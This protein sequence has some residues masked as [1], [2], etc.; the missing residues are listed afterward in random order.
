MGRFNIAPSID[1]K[2][3][4]P[5]DY[6]PPRKGQKIQVPK[7][8]VDPTFNPFEQGQKSQGRTI[9]PSGETPAGDWEK[10][11]EGLE[12][13]KPDDSG[14]QALII[15]SDDSPSPVSQTV[16]NAYLQI[17]K[18]FILTNVKSGVM[19][20]HQYRADYRI[21]Y[22]RIVASAGNSKPNAQALLFSKTVQ[23]TA[24]EDHIFASLKDEL[25]SLGFVF[26]DFGPGAYL[27]SALPVDFPESQLEDFLHGII[28]SFS[29]QEKGIEVNFRDEIAK[30]IA[31]KTA[32][33]AG[34]ILKNEEMEN[35]INTLFSTSM[36]EIDPDG[37]PVV[38][39]LLSE[40]LDRFF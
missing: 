40:E 36:P 18:K 1:F 23:L 4:T 26:E 12:D 5:F 13:I 17:E 9:V 38:R 28:D 8:T 19:L 7:V 15:P 32:V 25:P 31:K 14:E 27:F 29:F 21:Q 16:N 2:S 3:E 34:V 24:E 11:Y 33:K 35:L 30:R 20:V 39:I 37:K 6:V 22:E 10:L